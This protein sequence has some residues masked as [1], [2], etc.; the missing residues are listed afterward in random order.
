[1]QDGA[2]DTIGPVAVWF[3][4]M[5]AVLYDKLD[6]TDAA[7]VSGVVFAG[8]NVTSARLF[9]YETDALTTPGVFS[10]TIFTAV[11]Q[12]PHVMPSM[13]SA[14]VAFAAGAASSGKDDAHKNAALTRI[15]A[16][17]MDFI[18]SP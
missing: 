8:S 18:R 3:P 16:A 4:P 17:V 6:A 7:I 12:L 10:R 5:T 9:A 13:V 15:T 11:A 2:S 1:V 14:V